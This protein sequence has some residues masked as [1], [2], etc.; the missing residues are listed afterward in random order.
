MKRLATVSKVFVLVTGLPVMSA[1]VCGNCHMCK[2]GR[3]NL[4]PNRVVVGSYRNK[5]G[6]MEY[7]K[8]PYRNLYKLPENISYEEGSAD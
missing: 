3:Y 5:N 8:M 6:A 1:L 4:C 2:T 7:I